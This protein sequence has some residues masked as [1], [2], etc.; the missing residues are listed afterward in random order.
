MKLRICLIIAGA[1][2]LWTAFS[3]GY[4]CGYK[5]ATQR[6]VIFARDTA[7][8]GTQSSGKPVSEPYFTKGNPIPT[9]V[10]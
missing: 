8:T 9:E 3:F 4:R 5:H 2:A 7:D 1:V 6:A 10:K